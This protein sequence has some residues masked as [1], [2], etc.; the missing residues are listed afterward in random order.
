MRLL[1]D[2]FRFLSPAIGLGLE[3][4]EVTL[5]PVQ[6]VLHGLELCP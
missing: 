1:L 6:R 3:M 4:V 2:G 5:Q